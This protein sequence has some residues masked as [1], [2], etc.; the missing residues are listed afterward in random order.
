MLSASTRVNYRNFGFIPKGRFIRDI[1]GYLFGHR[2]LFKR[3]QAR[4]IL[5][6]LDLKSGEKA[7]DFGCG[8]GHFTVEMAKVCG[9]A[10]G[11]DLS[12][13]VGNI[14]IPPALEKKLNFILAKEGALPFEDN[15]FDVLLASEVIA[16]VTDPGVF[17]NEFRRVLRPGGRLVICNG[18]GHP[19]VEQAYKEKNSFF[20][21]ALRKYPERMPESYESYCQILNKSF[22]NAV[23]WFYSESDVASLLSKHGFEKIVADYSPGNI[24]GTYF[25][26][27][28]FV[29]YIKT[30][31]TH[32]HQKFLLKYFT[33]SLLRIF[34]NE[35][36][37]G[38]LIYVASNKK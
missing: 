24:A 5:N 34:E 30:G 21:W 37:K 18:A 1:Y 13:V 19:F 32:T 14:I 12:P 4:D 2:N 25:S 27:S 7:L 9:D 23:D 38:G 33:F 11:I 8:S 22:G 31:I 29:N 26:K 3:L 16:T 17:L 20:Q 35:K 6:A 28:Q 36:F 10:I 15:S